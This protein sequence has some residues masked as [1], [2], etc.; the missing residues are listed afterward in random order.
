V[1]SI[2]SKQTAQYHLRELRAQDR[3]ERI[4]RGL[5]E[6]A[7]NDED[8]NHE[9]DDGEAVFKAL[10]AALEDDDVDAFSRVDTDAFEFGDRAGDRE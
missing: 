2:D 6:L 3:V 4:S 8:P 9:T 1:T 7:D 10:I 5:Y